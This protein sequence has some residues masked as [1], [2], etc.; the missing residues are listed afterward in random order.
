MNRCIFCFCRNRFRSIDKYDI[1]LEQLEELKWQ[2]ANIIDVSSPKEYKEGHID[3]AISIPEYELRM[4]IGKMI[5]NKDTV[6]VVYCPSGF[7]S[8]R[9]QK[10]LKNMGY[11]NVYNLYNGFAKY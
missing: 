6:I 1:N 7:R 8:K 9:A 3:R 5:E 4:R 2:G 10:T 11:K